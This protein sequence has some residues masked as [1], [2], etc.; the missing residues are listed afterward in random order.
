MSLLITN[1]KDPGK[2]SF[3]LASRK[4]SLFF[5]LQSVEKSKKTIVGIAGIEEQH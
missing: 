3:Y 5:W 2:L 1:K 4:K